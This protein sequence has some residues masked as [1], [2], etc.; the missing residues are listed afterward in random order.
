MTPSVAA[1][2]VTHPSDATVSDYFFYV[3]GKR[4][5]RPSYLVLSLVVLNRRTDYIMDT[6]SPLTVVS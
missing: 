4:F 3:R 1:P 5:D 2:G 6:L